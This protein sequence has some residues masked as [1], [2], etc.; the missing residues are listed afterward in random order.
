MGLRKKHVM[1][2]HALLWD[3]RIPFRTPRRFSISHEYR[4]VLQDTTKPIQ[5]AAMILHSA[6]QAKLIESSRHLLILLL[7]H[8]RLTRIDFGDDAG[9]SKNPRLLLARMYHLN[10]DDVGARD[11]VRDLMKSS[12][13]EVSRVDGTCS[14][15]AEGTDL[16]ARCIASSHFRLIESPRSPAHDS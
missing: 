2:H 1:W 16:V 11:T 10:G 12:L 4:I 7:G 15:C 14:P 13:E 6:T 9:V 3:A 8:F 5:H